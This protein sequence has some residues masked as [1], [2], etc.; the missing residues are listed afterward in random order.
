MAVGGVGIVSG[1]GGALVEFDDF[2]R[3]EIRSHRE[4]SVKGATGRSNGRGK[5]RGSF[6]PLLTTVPR[7]TPVEMT[8][9]GPRLKV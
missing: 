8:Q 4:M 2:G 3:R 7:T 1:F 9:V 5:M 6:T